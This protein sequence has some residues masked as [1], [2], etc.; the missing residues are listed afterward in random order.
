MSKFDFESLEESGELAVAT[1]E[2]PDNQPD[3]EVVEGVPAVEEEEVSEEIVEDEEDLETE[4]EVVE[5]EKEVA[6]KEPYT[7]AEIQEILSSDGEVD[8]TRLSLAEQ[9]TMKAMQRGFTPKLQEAA[10]L[11][12]EVEELRKTIEAAKPKEQ[13]E[14]IFQ[15]YDQDPDSVIQYVDNQ[16]NEL[17]TTGDAGSMAQ[18]RQLES[19]KFEF[20]RRDVQKMREQTS[21]NT[22]QN[23]IMNEILSAVPDL[24]SKQSSLKEFALNELGYTEEELAY[25]TNPA[26]AGKNAVRAISRINTAFDKA[27]AKKSVTTKRVKK[28]T[29][30]EKPSS[31]GYEKPDVDELKQ[32]KQQALE[33]GNFSAFFAAL[34]ED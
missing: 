14:D 12:R 13:P 33:S 24:A 29:K 30:V 26:T 9:A 31:T 20:N 16:I 21:T 7:E 23:D 5:V 32:T 3:V 8:T 17:V 19:L 18:I 34:E 27:Q 25:E 11:R 10:E 1:E 28:A 2:S 4:E 15:A 6:K 22:Q